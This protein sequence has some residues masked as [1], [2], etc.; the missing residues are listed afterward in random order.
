MRTSRTV[1]RAALA[2]LLA[3][4][5]LELAGRLLFA[6]P[7]TAF[8][9]AADPE[10]L[11]E[12]RPGRHV[13]TGN[14]RR[15]PPYTISVNSLGCRAEELDAAPAAGRGTRVLFLGDSFTFG[16]G[17][18]RELIFSTL[19]GHS[20]ATTVGPETRVVN[21]ALEGYNFTQLVRAAEVRLA[22]LRPEHLV[23]V[24]FS[25]DLREPTRLDRF[26]GGGPLLAS[27]TR[28]SYVV[29]LARIARAMAAGAFDPP[30]L[31][32]AAIDRGFA[33][34][35]DAARRHHAA[36][37]WAV[38][39]EPHHPRVS[40]LQLLRQRGSTWYLAPALREPRYRI[41]S[42]GHLNELGHRAVATWLGP[43]LARRLT[44]TARPTPGE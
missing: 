9:L 26:I 17:L 39:E 29:R 36:V 7:Q 31:D 42:N 32:P 13:S 1:R 37:T 35:E 41:P 4:L 8:R 40:F 25:D 5:V 30:Y 18:D 28:W 24:I 3:V 33:R 15:I 11:Y 34:V 16:D 14:L 22:Q 12:L 19:I 10:L 20:L 38:L 21:C 2:V 27:L 44:E 43:L 23:I 6:G